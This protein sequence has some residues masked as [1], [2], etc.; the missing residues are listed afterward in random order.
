MERQVTKTLLKMPDKQQNRALSAQKL[1]E[2]FL[3]PG[4]SYTL[5]PCLTSNKTVS[6]SLGIMFRGA[7]RFS[8][9]P[10][11]L[12]NAKIES[13]RRVQHPQESPDM[14]RKESL[15]LHIKRE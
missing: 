5:S 15:R 12:D 11:D 7:K 1:K 6:F 2:V 4:G 14:T 9:P 10:G 13:E 3:P 8:L